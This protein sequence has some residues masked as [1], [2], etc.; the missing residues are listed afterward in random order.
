MTYT[1]M[2][3]AARISGEGE[4]SAEPISRTRSARG[5]H[6]TLDARAVDGVGSAGARPSP[7]RCPSTAPYAFSWKP[8]RK[9]APC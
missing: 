4:A 3:Q 7:A 6:R 5:L 2:I 9:D 1:T 8:Q